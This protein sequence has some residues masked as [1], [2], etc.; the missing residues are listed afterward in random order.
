MAF[1]STVGGASAN[2]YLSVADADTLAAY[3]RKKATWD[4]MTTAEKEIYLVSSTA[5]IDREKYAAYP[6][7]SDQRLKWPRKYVKKSTYEFSSDVQTEDYWDWVQLIDSN[8]WWAS[9]EI[10]EPLRL[11]VFELAIWFRR[12]DLGEMSIDEEDQELFSDIS[13]GAVQVKMRDNNLGMERLP[14]HIQ[15]YLKDLGPGV[16]I[17]GTNI[18]RAQRG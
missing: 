7:A 11:A 14:Q 9:D 3:H 16:W 5:R 13:T 12:I 1:D 2:S 8:F 18:K 4:A 17:G 15:G 6:T 10:P